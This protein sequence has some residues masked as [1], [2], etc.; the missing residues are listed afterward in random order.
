MPGYGG[1]RHQQNIGTRCQREGVAAKLTRHGTSEPLRAGR[2]KVTSR[3][4]LEHAAFELFAARTFEK[5]TVDEIAEAVGI[6]RRTF[7]RYFPSKNDVVW[8]AFDVELERLRGQL[9]GYPADLPVMDALRQALLDFNRIP[10]SEVS[11]HRRRMAL[12]LHVP[13]LQAHSTLRYADW[14]A[15]L[16]EFIGRRLDQPAASLVPQAIAYAT[17]GVAIAAYE[18]WLTRPAADGDDLLRLMDTAMREMAA[19][20]RAAHG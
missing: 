5:T 8:G 18:Q 2:R 6:G 13:A 3:I 11:W 17:L 20:F 9:A 19:G 7:F 15:V 16:A 10:P 4:E 12:I 14:R 1:G